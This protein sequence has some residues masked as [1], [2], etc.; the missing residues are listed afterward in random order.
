M[1]KKN[2]SYEMLMEKLEEIVKLMESNDLSL[3]ESIKKYE[4]GVNFSNKL[5]KILNDAE[6]KITLLT[7]QGEK[8]FDKPLNE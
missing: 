4:E 7:E 6:G 5:Y 2:E 3:E 1:A 8:K